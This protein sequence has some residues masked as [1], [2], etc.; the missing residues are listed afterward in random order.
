M[1]SLFQ[2]LLGLNWGTTLTGITLI[3]AAIGR[4]AIAYKTRDFA[5]I[6]AD[7]KLIMETVV[8][9]IAAFGFLKAKDASVTGVGAAAKTVDSAGTVTNVSGDVVGQ[10]A[11]P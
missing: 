8:A 5:A 2:K 3:I 11:K 6:F 10:Q 4:I 1:G 9:L 7:T